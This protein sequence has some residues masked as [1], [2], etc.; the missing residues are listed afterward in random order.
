LVIDHRGHPPG[1]FEECS[2]IDVEIAPHYSLEGDNE[3]ALLLFHDL[4]G[5][6]QVGNEKS[7]GATAGAPWLTFFS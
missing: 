7:Q 3:Y 6:E 2:C 5:A 4:I 1:G